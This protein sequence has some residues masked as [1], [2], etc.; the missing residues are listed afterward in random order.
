MTPQKLISRDCGIVSSHFEDVGSFTEETCN[1]L[2]VPGTC[3]QT[4]AEFDPFFWIGS[5]QKL[6]PCY[7]KIAWML[8]FERLVANLQ[9]YRSATNQIPV[10]LLMYCFLMYIINSAWFGLQTC[11]D[12]YLWII[13]IHVLMFMLKK[14]KLT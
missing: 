9:V 12:I 6:Y 7:I 11:Y 10:M 5:S 2:L 3:S 1:V 4:D 13:N 14:L 8:H